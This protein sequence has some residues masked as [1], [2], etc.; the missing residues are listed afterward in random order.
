MI[1]NTKKHV[2]PMLG[3]N[4]DKTELK[5]F[6]LKAFEL[7]VMVT[8]PFLPKSV[9]DDKEKLYGLYYGGNGEVKITKDFFVINHE[10]LKMKDHGFDA[11]FE[12]I[13]AVLQDN[14]YYEF[15]AAFEELEWEYEELK[16]FERSEEAYQQFR[17][18][19]QK[20]VDKKLN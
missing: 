9:I 18:A 5:E 14:I 7:D 3:K 2:S 16:Y 15:H 17:A 10:Y 19:V 4:L 11:A 13:F 6:L 1:L 8:F 20:Q 12:K